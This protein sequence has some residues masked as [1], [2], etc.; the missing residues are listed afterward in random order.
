MVR[1]V[2]NELHQIARKHRISVI[3]LGSGTHDATEHRQPNRQ[4]VD[5][6][7]IETHEIYE[8]CLGFALANESTHVACAPHFVR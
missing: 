1:R 8:Q 7:G 4:A 3:V 5:R 6:G 2:G